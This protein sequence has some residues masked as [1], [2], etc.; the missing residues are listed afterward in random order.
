MAQS[1]VAF[2]EEILD[3]IFSYITKPVGVTSMST[4]H[5]LP[6]G[7]DLLSCALSCRALS[8]PALRALWHTLVSLVPLFQLLSNFQRHGVDYTLSGDFDEA[9]L[10]RFDFY[11]S[12]VRKYIYHN[13]TIASGLYYGRLGD[14]VYKPLI[15]VRPRP[16]P[17]LTHFEVIPQNGFYPL[18]SLEWLS[19][20]V[21]PSLR[22][23]SFWFTSIAY[24]PQIVEYLQLVKLEAPEFHSLTI[25]CD[26]LFNY[27]D[28]NGKGSDMDTSL[29][30]L[31]PQL[32][33]LRRLLISFPLDEPESRLT[34]LPRI[35]TLGHM[36]H[37]EELWIRGFLVD[38]LNFEDD[39]VYDS[40][41][42]PS[43]EE[44][45]PG[46]FK[47]LKRLYIAH[48]YT[49]EIGT[50]NILRDAPAVE[51]VQLRGDLKTEED[52]KAVFR[53]LANQWS[54][55]LT[56]FI[57]RNDPYNS[58][59]GS[60]VKFSS[61]AA[62][63][64]SC[65]Q[66]QEVEFYDFYFEL[67]LTD[68][69]ISNICDA[70]PCLTEL[71]IEANAGNPED[72]PGLVSCKT[73]S[74][75]CPKLRHLT[76]PFNFSPHPC[77]MDPHCNHRLESVHF[78]VEQSTSSGSRP[79]P[80]LL[81]LELNGIFPYLKDVFITVV[82]TDPMTQK[83]A[84]RSPW[85]DV[86]DMVWLLQMIGKLQPPFPTSMMGYKDDEGSEEVLVV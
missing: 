31:L 16:L 21:S 73:L 82:Q 28:A 13:I 50:L 71:L 51:S 47:S 72:C 61:F 60:H 59:I 63:L 15:Q 52:C 41:V 24:V 74:Q 86:Y 64:Y 2:P 6:V 54:S 7:R 8:A 3:D 76:L 55:T 34:F 18:P 32:H 70:W 29:S 77:Y 46:S 67:Y 40:I 84:D 56:V 37:L 25:T 81:A 20:F 42:L 58:T 62:A 49:V 35:Q 83:L 4:V 79:S 17:N 30:A 5:Q 10:S 33:T 43:S 23:A 57:F 65:H 9:S 38:I 11:A 45:I 66:L 69:D 53:T 22:T 75:R 85:K 14:S 44:L 26:T 27:E 39:E 80:T 36:E 48:M 12:M 68:E 1:K 19:L 78:W